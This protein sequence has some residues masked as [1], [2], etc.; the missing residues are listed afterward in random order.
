MCALN[1]SS[2]S[3]VD[4]CKV[5]VGANALTVYF[6]VG[7]RIGTIGNNRRT[8]AHVINADQIS[9]FTYREV[10]PETHE[11]QLQPFGLIGEIFGLNEIAGTSRIEVRFGDRSSS[12]E[13]AVTFSGNLE[14]EANRG[15]SEDI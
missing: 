11:E 8:A 1:R 9:A 4:Y 3:R 6:E 10:Q 14:F 15:P 13:S 7:D 5:E 2:A 12:A